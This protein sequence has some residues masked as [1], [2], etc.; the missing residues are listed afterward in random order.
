M[1]AA[2][3]QNMPEDSV[4]VS[5]YVALLRRR[6]RSILLTAVIVL[7][8]AGG[9]LATATPS[10]TAQSIVA[11]N[12]ITSTP[13]ANNTNIN[14]LV[15]ANNE[16][17]VVESTAVASRAG[18][19]LG[20]SVPA[21]TLLSNVTVLVPPSSQM[22][23]IS[24]SASTPRGAAAG[25]N[26]FADAYLQF[27]SA[28]ALAQLDAISTALNK[29]IADLQN[30]IS[31]ADQKIASSPLTSAVH[32]DN[33][34]LQD[35]L[36][37]QVNTLRTEQAGLA[38]LSVNPGTLVST[39]TPPTSPAAPKTA[40]VL[41]AGAVIG[42]IIGL[43]V[44][45]VRDR[46]DHRVRALSD[47]ARQLGAPTLAGVPGKA[48]PLHRYTDLAVIA[49][50]TGPEAEMYRRLRAKLLVEADRNGL[51]SVLTTTPDNQLRRVDCAASLAVALAQIGRRVTLV[52]TD[53]S[54]LPLHTLFDVPPGGLSDA[55]TGRR[56]ASMATVA[57]PQLPS[58]KL[59][60]PEVD[61]GTLGDSVAAGRLTPIL[62]QLLAESD[63][64]IVDGPGGMQLGDLLVPAAAVDG[65]LVIA[66]QGRTQRDSVAGLASELRQVGARIL[67][68]V[69]LTRG[70]APRPAPVDGV[71]AGHRRT[72]SEDIP[73]LPPLQRVGAESPVDRG[74]G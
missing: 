19:L 12:P 7:A 74:N 3:E 69:L 11:V 59:L 13:F 34:V 45:F 62:A 41:V 38:S 39:A 31:A 48:R 68:G 61:S 36:S 72:T 29:Q 35:V 17:Q 70:S 57:V 20:T 44:G 66:E 30:Q 25:A 28:A 15:N 67:G 5:E 6:W 18:K 47:L 16:M 32:Q 4:E 27:R 55:L 49:E 26:A 56:S 14:Q 22:L 54:R 33:L 37:R 58:L 10:Y 50:P 65:I 23:I 42:L 53:L 64:L 8:A 63:Y 73:P 46:L 21:T 24:Y 40:L 1:N 52:G 9:Y 51:R 43:I 60:L 71:V 2:S